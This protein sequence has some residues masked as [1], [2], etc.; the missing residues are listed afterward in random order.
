MLN[1]C[2]ELTT[3]LHI[4]HKRYLLFY[5]IDIKNHGF[6]K[7]LCFTAITNAYLLPTR[8]WICHLSSHHTSPL[9]TLTIFFFFFWSQNG[10]IYLH[11]E[12]LSQLLSGC[13]AAAFI[14][15]PEEGLVSPK[16]CSSFL[17]RL[18]VNRRHCFCL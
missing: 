15:T 16:S 11:F 4:A 13:A 17:Q 5:L 10:S 9:K 14:S 6:R 18:M 2:L 8:K 7:N 12:M 1:Y 3:D